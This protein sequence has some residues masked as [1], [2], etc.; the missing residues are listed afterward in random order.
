MTLSLTYPA[1][2]NYPLALITTCNHQM[3]GYNIAANMYAY[4]ALERALELNEKVW[5][6]DVFHTQAEAL[7]RDIRS[8]IEKYGIVKAQDDGSLVCCNS[9]NLGF[10]NLGFRV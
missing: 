10:K 3:Y 2:P 7:M 4:A 9:M 5:K 8:G 6:M 1:H